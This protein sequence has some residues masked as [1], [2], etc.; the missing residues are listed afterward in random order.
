VCAPPYRRPQ[1]TAQLRLH[2][3]VVQQKGSGSLSSY[4]TVDV[5][6]ICSVISVCYHLAM[7]FPILGLGLA[8]MHSAMGFAV[9]APAVTVMIFLCILPFNARFFNLDSTRWSEASDRRVRLIASILGAIEAAKLG[10]FEPFFAAKYEALREHEIVEYARYRRAFAYQG[11][12][13]RFAPLDV[14]SSPIRDLQINWWWCLVRAAAILAFA[15]SAAN[16]GRP[17]ACPPDTILALPRSSQSVTYISAFL[18]LA[19]LEVRMLPS[20]RQ[21]KIDCAQAWNNVWFQVGWQY[22]L[23]TAAWSSLKRIEVRG[24]NHTRTDIN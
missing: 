23:L 16:G 21:R 8:I 18:V 11:T 20:P 14:R 15:I 19:T 5:E 3:V 22:G 24:G 9:L 4:L 1:T 10:A 17:C 7:L 2:I 12:W 13:V 6:R